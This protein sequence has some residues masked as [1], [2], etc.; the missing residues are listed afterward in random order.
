M[1]I[2]H[3][4]EVVEGQKGRNESLGVWPKMHCGRFGGKM[5]D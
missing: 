1:Y 3:N 4:L 5:N 2:G